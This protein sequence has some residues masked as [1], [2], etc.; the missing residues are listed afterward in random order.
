RAIL[1]VSDSWVISLLYMCASG[2]FLGFA[3]A[4]GQVLQH[5]FMAGGQ[6]HPQAALHAAEIAFIG[7]LLGSLARIVGGQVSDRFGG[8]R[9]ALSVFTASVFAGGLLVGVSMLATVAGDHGRPMTALTM[10]GYIVGFIAL[11]VFCGVGKGAVYK[12][13]PTVFEERSRELG[14]SDSARHHWARVRSSALIGF[15]GAFGAL[16]GVGVNLTLRQ[17][18]DAEGTET[19]AFC[20]FLACYAG[21]AVLTWA[22]YVRDRGQPVAISASG[23]SRAEESITT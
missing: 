13:I 15:A 5:N 9:V 18:Y 19:P 11:F 2:S 17:S 4:F 23:Q 14:L 1:S 22:R 12:L 21:A 6:S 20:I 8:G 16:G 3:F 10:T 7:P